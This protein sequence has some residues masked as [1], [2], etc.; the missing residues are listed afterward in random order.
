MQAIVGLLGIV[1]GFYGIFKIPIIL[2]QVWYPE[3]VEAKISTDYNWWQ[4]L[5]FAC[6]LI[7]W[8]LF[9][10]WIVVQLK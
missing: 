10:F 6:L 1:V 8:V 7:A 2:D 4:M 3:A 5:I 9:T